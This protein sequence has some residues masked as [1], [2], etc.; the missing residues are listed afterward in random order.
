MSFAAGDSRVPQL[1]QS[2]LTRLRVEEFVYREAALLDEWQLDEWLEL[3][4]ADGSYEVTP[5]GVNH[6][7]DISRSEVYFLIGDDHKRLEHRIK[8]LKRPNA[9]AEVPR[10]K[11]RHLYSNVVVADDDGSELTAHVNF[12]TFRTKRGTVQYFGRIRFR[13]RC[14][15]DS[16]R[17]AN[18]RIMMDI[19]TLVP[20]GRV[21]ILL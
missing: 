1:P 9:H 6:A 18:K 16:F 7:E 19:D 12:N 14:V 13:L 3:F 15:E 11:V 5:P 2:L 20:Q 17:I 4:D 21:S 10:S 8:R